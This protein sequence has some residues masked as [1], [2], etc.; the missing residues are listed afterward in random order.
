MKRIADMNS[1]EDLECG[2]RAV[3]AHGESWVVSQMQGI[4]APLVRVSHVVRI[5]DRLYAVAEDETEEKTIDGLHYPIT[6]ERAF[7]IRLDN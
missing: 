7:V 4:G 6:G 1:V 3:P 2:E 5:G